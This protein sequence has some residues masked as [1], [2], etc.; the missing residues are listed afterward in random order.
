ML[1]A[2]FLPLVARLADVILSLLS[3]NGASTT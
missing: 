1:Q 3:Y 2:Y